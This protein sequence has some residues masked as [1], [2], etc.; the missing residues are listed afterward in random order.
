MAAKFRADAA[1]GARDHHDAAAEECKKCVDPQTT[2]ENW[3]CNLG[4][5]REALTPETPTPSPTPKPTPTKTAQKTTKKTT[6]STPSKKA[7]KAPRRPSA[8][9]AG[10]GRAPSGPA[11]MT[12]A[13]GLKPYA[14]QAPAAAAGLPGVLP[15]PEIAADPNAYRDAAGGTAAMPQT[16]LIS[17]V[18]ASGQ[19]NGQ[20]LLVAAAAGAAGAVGA[21]NI[22][23]AGRAVRRRRTR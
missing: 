11:P 10:A 2:V 19:D 7:A 20:L 5:L 22:S 13:G 14:G 3:K 15:T 16:R 18:A 1:A 9:P 4:N 17:P 21:L 12:D 23:V 6:T 8:P